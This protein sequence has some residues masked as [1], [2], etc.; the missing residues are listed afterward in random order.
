[1]NSIRNYPILVRGVCYLNGSCISHFRRCACNQSA[2]ISFRSFEIPK[3]EIALS[4]TLF[5]ISPLFTREESAAKV[6]C[7]ESISKNLLKLGS[8]V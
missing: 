8:G 2:V 3:S 1:M 4:K 5:E 7:C 6:M